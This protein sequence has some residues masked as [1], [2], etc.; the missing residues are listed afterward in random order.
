MAGKCPKCEKLVPHVVFHG[1]DARE[2]F[3][4]N[5]WKAISYCCP[6]CQTVLGVQ[7]DPIALKTEVVKDLAKILR[8]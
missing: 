1:I 4:P 6:S 8:K 7:I 2:S 5:N 3:G